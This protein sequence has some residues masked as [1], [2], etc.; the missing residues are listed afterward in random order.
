MAE[1]VRSRVVSGLILAWLGTMTAGAQPKLVL[2]RESWDFGEIWRSDEAILPVVITNEGN[3]RLQVRLASQSMGMES[4]RFE[5]NVLAPGESVTIAVAVRTSSLSGKVTLNTTLASNDPERPTARI[6]LTGTIQVALEREP[7][8]KLSIRTLYGRSGQLGTIR[9][10]NPTDEPMR[11][12]LTGTSAPWLGASVKWIENGK[13]AEIQARTK[14]QME[15]GEIR[16]ALLRFSTGLS[17]EKEITVPVSVQVLRTVQANP[18]ALL[19]SD[20]AAMRSSSTKPV[21]TS[22]RLEYYGSRRNF[23]ITKATSSSP[24]VEVTV[25]PSRFPSDAEAAQAPKIVVV[26]TAIVQL[27]ATADFPK[28]DVTLTFETNDPRH[29][30]V[31]VLITRDY[32]KHYGLVYG[33]YPGPI[34]SV[35]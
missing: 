2:S 19:V 13:V 24:T 29:P 22:V 4:V 35:R 28:E 20:T 27:P 7:A 21:K 15:P 31:E 32:G 17:T 18:P 10:S 12:R 33:S 8:D 14:Q 30:T 25:Q 26:H 6:E 11:L 3:E 16:N 1:R 34:Q 5:K 9:I 23:A